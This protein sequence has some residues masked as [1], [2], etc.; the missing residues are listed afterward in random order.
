MSIH[1]TCFNSG[2]CDNLFIKKYNLLYVV[3]QNFH[4]LFV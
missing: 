2:E 3:I 4:S 1:L